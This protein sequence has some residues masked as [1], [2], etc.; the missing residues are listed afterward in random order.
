MT[1]R[2]VIDLD[3]PKCGAKGKVI[4][5]QSINV[6]L[7]PSLREKLLVGKINIFHCP[8]CEQNSFISVPLL[9]HDMDR[10]FMVQFFPFSLIEEKNFLAQFTRDA[11]MIE[12]QMLPRKLR[13]IYKRTQ[14]VFDMGELVRYVIFREKLC[15]AWK[16]AS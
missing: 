13:Q 3:C 14:V 6:S 11:E 8:K 16:E 1:Q 15:E 12:T 4:I 2:A 7:D 5:Y 10:K 9:Y